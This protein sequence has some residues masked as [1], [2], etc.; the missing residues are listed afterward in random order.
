MEEYKNMFSLIGKSLY[1]TVKKTVY[2][3]TAL[4][5]TIEL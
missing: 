1:Q 5:S 4:R 2:K 3:R